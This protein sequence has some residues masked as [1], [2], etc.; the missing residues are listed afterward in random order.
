MK[1]VLIALAL[2]TV[3]SIAD[4]PV[5]F[6][7]V[8][9][10]ISLIFVAV[11]GILADILP[12]FFWYWLGAK[13]GVEGFC[14]LPIFHQKPE[15]LEKIGRALDHYGGYLLFGSKFMYA[16]GIPTQVM[17]GAHRF[18]LKRAVLANSLGSIGWLVI[19]YFLAHI[20]T[21]SE[22]AEAGLQDAQLD[23]TAF[24]AVS[25]LLYIILSK[26]LKHFTEG[27]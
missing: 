13:I 5:M 21:S 26:T 24:V 2:L 14:K 16:F 23:F 19:L 25:I 4:V 12:D 22:A 7:A 3:G 6:L 27:E 11:A 20:F 1:Y 9:G 8:H 10:T 15:R 17:A 18:P